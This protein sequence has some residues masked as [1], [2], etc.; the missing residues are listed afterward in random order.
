[1]NHKEMI[2]T[3]LQN[4][5][6][7]EWTAL[8]EKKYRDRTGCF[9]VE[10]VRSV[11]E[12]VRSGSDVAWIVYDMDRG[13]PLELESLVQSRLDVERAAVTTQVMSKC[14]GTDSPPPVF[15]IV[16]KPKPDHEAL[17]RSNALVVVLDGVKDPGNVGTII[18]SADAVGADAVILGE[19]CVDLYNP[20]TVRST[21]GSLFHLP[22]L[23]AKLPDLLAE[24]SRHGIA[25]IGTSLQADKS[26]YS[27]DWT[28]PTWLM[29]GSEATGLSE[30]TQHAMS[31]AV[32]IPM[33]GQAESLN[34]AMAATALLFEA[35]R[36]R[37]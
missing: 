21:M 9:I 6:V 7:K 3:S 20:K 10:G 4:A 15:G 27:Y 12:A 34:V 33:R 19:G 5:R 29:L 13:M 36:Q 16:R 22:V 28:Q 11:E 32:I 2:I 1:M 37:M 23:E 26:C 8:L 14:T 17:Y 30:T 31:D 18:R 24:A 35:Q 25:L